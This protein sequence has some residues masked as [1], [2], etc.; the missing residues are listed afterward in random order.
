MLIDQCILCSCLLAI[1]QALKSAP[2]ESKLRVES[3]RLLA[4][5]GVCA[6]ALA[7]WVA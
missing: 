7:L 3:M 4:Y 6:F 5:A 2:G 1:E